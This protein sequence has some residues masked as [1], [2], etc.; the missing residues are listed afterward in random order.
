MGLH[1]AGGGALELLV[2]NLHGFQEELGKWF[3]RVPA[4]SLPEQTVRGSRSA[5]SDNSEKLGE[6]LG[7][8]QYLFALFLSRGGAWSCST[9]LSELLV[10]ASKW[11]CG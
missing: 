10:G 7:K 9:A 1:P 2:Q 8:E 4:G 11:L 6:G 3:Q 5:W